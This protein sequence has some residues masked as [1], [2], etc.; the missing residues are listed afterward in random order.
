MHNES[1]LKHPI[2]YC[3]N[4]CFDDSLSDEDSELEE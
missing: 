2:T 4:D 3:V 1:I